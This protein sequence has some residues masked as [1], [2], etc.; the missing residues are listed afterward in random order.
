MGHKA[1]KVKDS[2]QGGPGRHQP[3]SLCGDW[4]VRR[5]RPRTAAPTRKRGAAESDQGVLAELGESGRS[6]PAPAG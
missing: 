3:R 4:E 2:L 6:R 5:R 1:L